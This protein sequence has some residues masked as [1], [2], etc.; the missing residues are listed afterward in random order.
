[1]REGLDINLLR[2]LV[3]LEERRSVSLVAKAMRRSQPSI[4]SAL[5]RLRKQMGDPLFLR[6]GPVMV[7]T[8]RAASVVA[9][10][11]AALDIVDR[12]V[13]PPSNFDPAKIDQPVRLGMTDAGEIVFLPRI[14]EALRA[15]MPKA[16]I[17]SH[18][19]LADIV[20]R[21][22]ELGRI[23]L[24]I[25]YFPD[26][27]GQAFSQQ[28]LFSDT[29]ACLIRVDHPIRTERLTDDQFR[30]L[31]HAVVRAE[32]RTEE[33]M[34]RFLAKRAVRRRVAFNTPHFASIPLLI[35]RSNLIATVPV[36]IARHFVA[37]NK[38]L[39]IVGLP[40]KP[41]TIA[42][43]QFWHCRYQHDA[44]SQWLRARIFELFER[45]RSA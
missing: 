31:E 40:F 17:S 14:F 9:A 8:P 11:R 23:D 19:P 38:N 33:V 30:K 12:Q 6:S 25:G 15:L 32:S 21:E 5:G 18:S 26:L 2:I 16:A 43:K 3:A 39:R 42:L 37:T 27:A 7:P 28:V 44:R 35:A 41:P 10:A 1:M 29:Y 22:L 45:N 13:V 24:A 4:S 36:P 20:G 34:E